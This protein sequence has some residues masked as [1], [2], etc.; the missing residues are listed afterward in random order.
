MVRSDHRE[1]PAVECCEL[2]DIEPLCD[3]DQAGVD[4]TEPK[5]C[6]RVNELGDALP[7]LRCQ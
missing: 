7:V 2:L 4:A 6:I 5:V 3:R 1:V